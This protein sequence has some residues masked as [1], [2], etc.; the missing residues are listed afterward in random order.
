MGY[1]NRKFYT[2]LSII[3]LIIGCNAEKRIYNRV[4]GNH[5]HFERKGKALFWFNGMHGIDPENPMFKDIAEA[6]IKFKPDYVLTEGNATPPDDSLQSILKGESVYVTY[7]AQQQKIPWQTSEPSDTCIFK[8]LLKSYDKDEIFAMYFIR[9]MVQ[10]KR[11]GV[12]TFDSTAVSFAI[13]VYLLLFNT[14]EL[15]T[16]KQL[17]NKLLPYTNINSLTNHNWK[18]FDAKKYLYF[19][20]NQIHD[21]Y[22]AVAEYRN[23]YLLQLIEQQL[24]AHD[25]LFIMIGFD[26]AKYIENELISLFETEI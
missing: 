3:V 22:L 8:H 5:L 1:F 24:K 20:E 19:S 23:Q 15:P 21:I 7:L 11:E 14:Q 17:S 16:L 18:D 9:Q 10:W 12:V 2:L 25:R 6:F 13:S 26:H 4:G